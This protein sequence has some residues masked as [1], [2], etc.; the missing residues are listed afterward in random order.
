MGYQKT[1]RVGI[2]EKSCYLGI[3]AKRKGY[4]CQGESN[5]TMRQ[6]SKVQEIK[7]ITLCMPMVSDVYPRINKCIINIYA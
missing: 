6:K 3:S 7:K 4:C 1:F 2:R 5:T